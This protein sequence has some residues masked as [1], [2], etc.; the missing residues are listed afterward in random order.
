MNR[1]TTAAHESAEYLLSESE[2]R[3][4]FAQQSIRGG[5]G[6]RGSRWLAVQHASLQQ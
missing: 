6:A 2:L 5:L 4:E 1:A 3:P